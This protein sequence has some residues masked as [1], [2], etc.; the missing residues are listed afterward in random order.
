ME[1]YKKFHKLFIPIAFSFL[2]LTLVVSGFFIFYINK[3]LVAFIYNSEIHNLKKAGRTSELLLQRS[4]ILA[5][6]I[7][8]DFNLKKLL[9]Y[10]EIEQIEELISLQQLKSYSLVIPN[11]HSI[12]LYNVNQYQFYIVT[13]AKMQLVQSKQNFFDKAIINLMENKDVVNSG[14]PITRYIPGEETGVFTFLFHFLGK[15]AKIPVSTIVIN[16]SEAWLQEQIE[17]AS[18]ADYQETVVIG[19]EGNIIMGSK[20]AAYKELSSSG[21]IPKV[22]AAVQ[23]SQ[24]RRSTSEGFFLSSN[25]Q[26]KELITY[27][28]RS[29]LG[30]IFIRKTPYK[31]I[32]G[33]VLTI[34][35]VTF[36][37]T[38]LFILITILISFLISRRIFIP[39]RQAAFYTEELERKEEETSG[40]INKELLHSFLMEPNHSAADAYFKNLEGLQFNI[41]L[42]LPINCILFSLDPNI[43][44]SE[45]LL[46]SKD[47]LSLK[48]E[49][50]L[51]QTNLGSVYPCETFPFKGGVLLALINSPQAGQLTA[52]QLREKTEEI[53]KILARELNTSFS[54]VFNPNAH[55]LLEAADSI[56]DLED[57]VKN[58]FIFGAGACINL[59]E[60]NERKRNSVEVSRQAEDEIISAILNAQYAE[61]KK[62]CA[63]ILNRAA[64]GTHR[65]I[66]TVY[67]RLIA[68]IYKAVEKSEKPASQ[69][70]PVSFSTVLQDAANCTN[71]GELQHLLFSIISSIETSVSMDTDNRN[72]QIVLAIQRIIKQRYNDC[73]LSS[74]M[75]SEELG[76]SAPYIGRI[77]K[78]QT[79]QSLPNYI[80]AFR[81]EKS[82]EL[83]KS[84]ELPIQT[85]LQE[86][87]Y[88][89]TSH[90]YSVFR[91]EC[92]ITPKAFRWKYSVDNKW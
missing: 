47:K 4:W 52:H 80:N 79:G 88:N 22:I 86:T 50:D 59:N 28:Y 31:H 83:L 24:K 82:K 87:G 60:I 78:D 14:R 3:Q 10:E 19:T 29:D 77:F 91:R 53:I 7:H 49:L 36:I 41:D 66:H 92:G 39:I 57:A 34:R 30:W 76:L 89:N 13:E 46:V 43:S 81:I 73:N 62:V 69:Q 33:P 27:Y 9:Y 37:V 26:A 23:S 71:M 61:A 8:N 58:R 5:Q 67:T 21:Y 51:I 63:T 56:S 32:I 18:I 11:L 48:A 16:I 45:E 42:H 75:I 74:I 64:E 6:Q 68:I 54:A 38:S 55:T 35:N 85:I 15:R 72:Q 1:K 20:T 44:R 90:F 12:Y 2:V 17:L 70:F 65:T 40:I 84:T 25:E